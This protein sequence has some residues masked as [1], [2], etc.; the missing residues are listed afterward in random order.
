M[1][2]DDKR[3]AITD[4]CNEQISCTMCP[5]QH[6]TF[7]DECTEDN[8]PERVVEEWYKAIVDYTLEGDVPEAIEQPQDQPTVIENHDNVNHPSH[9]ETGKIEC[10]EAMV[11]T[12]GVE[13]VKNFCLCNCFKYLWRHRGKEGETSIDKAL[14]YLNKY[15]ELRDR[16]Q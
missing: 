12:Q 13:A 3:K 9:Y 11:E 1:T 14:W 5:L 15:V 16:D 8:A 6:A 4:F 2:I 10:I 7:C